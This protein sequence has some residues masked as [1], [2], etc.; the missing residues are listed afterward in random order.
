MKKAITDFDNAIAGNSE[1][2]E[3]YEE[4]GSAKSAL[5]QTDEAKLDFATAHNIRGKTKLNQ[6]QYEAAIADFD[7]AIQ[8][9]PDFAKVYNNRGNAKNK[10]EKYES[11]IA[12]FDKAIQLN[13]D[14]ARVYNNRGNAKNK[15]EKY[16]SAITDFDKAIQLSGAAVPEPDIFTANFSVA[17]DAYMNRAHAKE[18]LGLT[19]EAESDRQA[20]AALP[21]E[22]DILEEA[23]NQFLLHDSEPDNSE[24]NNK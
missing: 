19:E 24:E 17:R 18:S 13:P 11:A 8:L 2:A 10:L 5:G 1:D 4:R 9:N 14:F 20:A 6:S 3:I 15:L 16:E 12:D 22:A 21:T 7:K 23:L